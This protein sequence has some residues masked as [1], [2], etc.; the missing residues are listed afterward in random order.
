MVSCDVWYGC[1]VLQYAG[2][3]VISELT[4][5]MLCCAV[6]SRAGAVP[7]CNLL[8]CVVASQC[9]SLSASLLVPPVCTLNWLF[10]TAAAFEC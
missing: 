6:L 10:G 1:A 5:V 2:L 7:I 4:M 3:S 8:S 9:V